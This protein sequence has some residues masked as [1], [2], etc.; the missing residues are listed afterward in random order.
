IIYMRE[1]LAT[2]VAEDPGI[3]S[4]LSCWLYEEF[5]HSR[6][7][8]KL[9]DTQG[10]RIEP[11]RFVEIRRRNSGDRVA[12]TFARIAS[13]LS[14]HFPAIHM[15]WGAINELTAV[16]AYQS[17][18]ERASHPMVTKVLSQ[19]VKDERRHFSF[20]FNQARI[21]LQ[22]RAAQILT[23]IALRYFWNP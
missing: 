10:V 23:T 3:S 7:L 11:Q 5:S 2:T 4:F 1:L 18:M 8:T 13:R 16:F 14:K 9:L 20:Y 6:T 19:I 15:T 22:H 21:R 12:Q 17:L